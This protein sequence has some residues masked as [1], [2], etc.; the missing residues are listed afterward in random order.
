MPISSFFLNGNIKGAI[1]YMRD[2]EEFRDVL[3]AYV[4][5]FENC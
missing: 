1:A 2:H 5:I 4:S 3:P